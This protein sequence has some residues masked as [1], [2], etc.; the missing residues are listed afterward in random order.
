MRIELK[1]LY[2]FWSNGFPVSHVSVL[3]LVRLVAVFEWEWV[4]CGAVVLESHTFT[5]KMFLSIELERVYIFTLSKKII[6]R[7]GLKG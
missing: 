1:L 2:H 7:F 3:R 4:I 5:K 6:Q